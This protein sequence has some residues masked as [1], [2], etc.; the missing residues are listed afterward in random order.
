MT[1][2]YVMFTTAKLLNEAGFDAPTRSIYRTNRTAEYSFVEY[3]QHIVPNDLYRSQLDG[4]QYE[5]LAPTQA[6]AARWIRERH[7]IFVMPQPTLHGWIFDL[8]DLD[9]HH[10]IHFGEVETSQNYEYA[11]EDGLREAL[12]L[13]IKNKNHEKDNVR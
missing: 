13:I 4:Y 1:E 8:F 9:E 10:F 6:L 5:Y 3:N 11:L 2:E 12:R 7:H